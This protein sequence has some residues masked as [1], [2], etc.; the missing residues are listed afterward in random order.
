LAASNAAPPPVD[1]PSL[2]ERADV[3]VIG[4]GVIGTSVAWHLAEAT[5][6]DVVCLDRHTVGSGST[7]RSA[8]AF[9]Q[10]FSAVQ[11]VRMSVYSARD[12]LAFPERFGVE[13]VFVQNGYLFLYKSAS[14]LEA[15]AKRVD[16]QHR[17]GVLEAAV[18]TPDEANRLPDLVGAFRTEA[19][20]GATWCPTDG[21]LKPSEIAMAYAGA[22]RREGARILANQRVTGIERTNGR[23]SGVL[24][25]GR[26]RIR[27]DAVVL[28][29]GWWSRF[30]AEAAG[31][32]IPLTAVKRYLYIT[33][34]FTSRRV[35][36]F[37]L[38]VGD[39]GPY[40]RPE[41]NGLMMGWDERPPRPEG[42]DRYPSPPQDE[43]ALEAGQDDVESG[44]GRGIDDYGY[45]VLAQLAEFI[46]FL[47]EEGGVEH[48]A[49]GY[50]EITP[51][52]KAI[53]GED[54][55]L[56]GLFHATG[57]SGHGI[58]HAPAAG[59]AISDLIRGEPPP[60]DL[61]GFALQPLLENRPRVDPERMVI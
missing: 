49:C 32:P 24:V 20:A 48:V 53:L 39:L 31:C 41:S 59:R 27:C 50:Y 57:F 61:E 58:M 13:P 42:I 29:A 36:H 1:R 45:E 44:F 14:D 33:P 3:V 26:D 52:D 43:D 12:Y 47:E 8:A 25:N 38:I 46:P 60:F 6:L 23:V 28:A 35:D 54:P 2:P 18:L 5:D 4:A 19:L 9:R 22:A 40:T 21:F 10:Q 17:E 51:D 34:Q 55:R 11:H 37:P 56:G 30:A 7:S 15:A 16:L